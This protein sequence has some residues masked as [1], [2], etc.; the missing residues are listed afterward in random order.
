MSFWFQKLFTSYSFCAL[1]SWELD[2]IGTTQNAY[3]ETAVVPWALVPTAPPPT[4]PPGLPRMRVRWQWSVL[5]VF[6]DIIEKVSVL[7][8]FPTE[9]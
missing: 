2:C 7:Y 3:E 9:F 4:Y 1:D 8:S 5:V 6:W